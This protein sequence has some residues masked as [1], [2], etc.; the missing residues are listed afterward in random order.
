[1][2]SRKT[3]KVQYSIREV[4][5]ITSLKPYVLRY[6]ETEF[7]ELHPRKDRSGNRI[8]R[9]EDIKL[10][11]LIKK[12]LYQE[13]YTIAG[14]RQRLKTMKQS[15]PQMA[16]SFEDLRSE[17]TLFEIKK[18]LENLLTL[19]EPSKSPAKLRH[20]FAPKKN[21]NGS[22]P[23]STEAVPSPPPAAILSEP[24]SSSPPDQIPD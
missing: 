6:W 11:F 3:Q 2:P 23:G 18:E 17:D 10:I 9:L 19:F 4:S 12:L 24:A 1:M 22:F 8:Y 5:R 15:S 13:K 14:A 20:G 16:L 21:K 7:S